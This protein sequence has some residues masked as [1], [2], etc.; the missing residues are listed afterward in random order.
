M[1]HNFEIPNKPLNSNVFNEETG[2]D[3]YIRDNTLVIDGH[4]SREEAQGL[5]DAHNP[6]APKEPTIE[7][8]LASVGLN[9]SDLKSALGL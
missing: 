9:L 7:D 3:L 1:L 5:L 8:K 2:F 6:P 4:C